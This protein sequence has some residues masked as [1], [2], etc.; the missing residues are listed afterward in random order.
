MLDGVSEIF[1]NGRSPASEVD[2]QVQA[3]L[4]QQIRKI[5][6][7]GGVAQ[8]KVGTFPLEQRRPWI[9]S[10][11]DESSIVE[12]CRLTGV[13]RSGLYYTPVGRERREHL[14]DASV[15]RA[16]YADPVLRDSAYDLVVGDARS[17]GQCEAGSATAT[18]H[19]TGSDLSQTAVVDASPGTP[20]LPIPVAQAGDCASRSGECHR[21]HVYPTPAGI[22]LSAGHH[23]LVQP[24][25]AGLGSVHGDGQWIL[26]VGAGMGA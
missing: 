7:R 23:G 19:G 9:E 26:R 8:K 20:D 16:V 1:S 18:A 5:T 15:G 6:D 2:E 14:V 12:Q 21:K 10:N 24:V 11:H 17:A 13:S 25:R 22:H 3:L 4:Y